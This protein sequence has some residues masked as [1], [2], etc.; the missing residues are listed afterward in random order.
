LTAATW[1]F[2]LLLVVAGSGK[3]A[4]PAGTGDAL[5]ALGLPA[6]AR[7]ARVLGAAEV[8][9]GGTVLVA[10]GRALTALL[11]VAYA[12]FAVVAQGQRRQ[13]GNCGCFGT[14]TTPATALHVWF[15]VAAATVAAGAVAVPGASLPAT[16][17]DDPLQGMLTVL[18]VTV[19][20]GVLQLVLTAVP[21]LHTALALVPPRN[22]A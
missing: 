17:V 11:V 15:D 1:V 16:V 8:C 20:T 13:G 10:G 9:V 2:A 3:L 6:D 19:V 5:R 22:D 7:L 18:L 14:T 4:R 12:V 21:D